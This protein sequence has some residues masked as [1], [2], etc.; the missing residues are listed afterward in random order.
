MGWRCDQGAL[1]YL[2]SGTGK[3]KQRNHSNSDRRISSM[4]STMLS[5]QW[6]VS[7]Y[8]NKFDKSKWWKS[9]FRCNLQ[10]SELQLL[11]SLSCVFPTWKTDISVGFILLFLIFLL[12]YSIL[13]QV[14]LVN[15]KLLVITH[16]KTSS[17][18]FTYVIELESRNLQD[19]VW[20]K[21]AKRLVPGLSQ[22]ID[23]SQPHCCWAVPVLE[24]S[25]KHTF[26]NF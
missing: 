3:R 21:I 4:G 8:L 15:R 2:R 17:P 12:S 16:S 5:T 24:L 13:R 14:C 20:W 23:H 7:G 1:I 19:T 9:L 10:I 18:R 6:W 26:R 25:Q 11:I 22:L